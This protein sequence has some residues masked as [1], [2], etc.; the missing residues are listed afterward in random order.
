MKRVGELESLANS[1]SESVR[2][3]SVALQHQ[4]KANKLVSSL[5]ATL[6]NTHI[7]SIG[8]TSNG[9]Q[10]WQG[11]FVKPYIFCSNVSEIDGSN[12]SREHTII[13][14]GNLGTS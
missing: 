11:L 6:R 2:E 1:L 3:K 8:G 5:S 4:K 10:P 7:L 14:A 9:E 12:H 13:G